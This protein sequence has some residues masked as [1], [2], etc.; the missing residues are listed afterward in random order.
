M[1]REIINPTKKQDISVITFWNKKTEGVQ[2]T[3]N[4]KYIFFPT[5]ENA[6][7]FFIKATEKLEAQIKQDKTN[8]PWWQ[9]IQ[10]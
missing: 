1:T 3:I 10:K 4:D 9:E 8:P 7:N 5:R 2:L 6:I